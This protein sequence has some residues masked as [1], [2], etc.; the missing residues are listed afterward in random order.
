M[1]NQRLKDLE[2]N[3]AKH[4]RLL[5]DFENELLYATDPK[6][7]ARYRQNIKEQKDYITHYK[8]E[9]KEVQQELAD[10]PSAP[11]PNTLTGQIT[12]RQKILILTAIPHG[13]RLDKEIREVEGA[14][15]RATRRDLFDVRTRTAVRPQ[16]IRRAVAE[17]KPLVVHFCGHGLKDG[18]LLL[19]D[20]GENNKPVPPQGL[21]TLFKHYSDYVGCVLLNACYSVKTADAISQH[22]NYVIGMNREIGDRVAIVFAQGFYDGLGYEEDNQDV[23]QKA[24]DEGLTAIALEDFSQESIPVL[25][26]TLISKKVSGRSTNIYY[27]ER[28]LIE[29]KCSQE[30]S[31]SDELTCNKSSNSI[32]FSTDLLQNEPSREISLK[33]LVLNEQIYNYFKDFFIPSIINPVEYANY[34]SRIE[35]CL[36]GEVN[37]PQKIIL[38]EGH[39]GTGKTSLAYSIAFETGLPFYAFQLGNLDNNPQSILDIFMYLQE[40]KP[41][42][43]FVD[44]L[45]SIAKRRLGRPSA[46]VAQLIVEL[47]KIAGDEIIF[48][49]ATNVVDMIDPTLM[50]RF[51]VIHFL[52][53]NKVEREKLVRLYFRPIWRWFSP[54]LTVS[55]ITNLM[56][57][58]PPCCWENFS[59]SVV[60]EG[61]K[62]PEYQVTKDTLRE[63]VLS[64]RGRN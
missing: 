17:E 24:F 21:A 64:L 2:D 11:S 18:S 48:I 34:L 58:V 47:D 25:K 51:H 22:I 7:I 33:D 4:E 28:S 27:I 20:D 38:F 44:E 46:I 36:P 1:T 16:D 12:Q 30:I 35:N 63:Y 42:I 9:K 57:N 52:M 60:M 43:C 45:D 13:L 39:P 41:C 5:K 26:K 6:I 61:R 19:E 32:A 55:E 50:R 10:K 3:I 23:F 62:H 37:L 59:M 56:I 8:S 29:E 40:L 54:E 53:P 49:A 15:R 31:Q 14:I